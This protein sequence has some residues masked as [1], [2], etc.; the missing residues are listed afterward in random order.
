MTTLRVIAEDAV[1]PAGAGLARYALEL[2]R[3]LVQAAPAGTDVEFVFAAHPARDID[4]FRELLPGASA[5]HSAALPRGPLAAAWAAGSMLGAAAA[6]VHAPTLFAPIAP[7]DRRRDGVQQVATIHDTLAWTH[8]GSLGRANAA[9]TR[10]MARR[11]AR[12]ADAIVVPTHAVADQLAELLNVGDRLRVIGGAVSGALTAPADDEAEARASWLK[13]PA[14]YVL[15]HGPLDARRGLDALVAAMPLIDADVALLVVGED[16]HRGR[17][18]SEA[19]MTA[20]LPEGR[21]RALGPVSDADLALLLQRAA[22]FVAP[23][24]EEGFGLAALEAL[25]LGTP[26]VHSDAPALVEVAG[27][28]GLAVA[29]AEGGSSYAERLADAIGR[30]LGDAALAERLRVAGLDRAKAFSWRDSAAR[31][32]QLHADL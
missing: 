6:M 8:P 11:A 32:W 20:G 5:Y 4:R 25:T 15:A 21:V 22:V 19:A 10:A 27:G 16:E 23:S 13:L 2:S 17:R 1:T 9:W 7:H 3:A 26:L 12:H 14:R 31:V 30:V 29:R 18:L 24:R 28:A